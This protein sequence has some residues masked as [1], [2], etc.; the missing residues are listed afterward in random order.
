MTESLIF[1]FSIP[2]TFPVSILFVPAKNQKKKR[3]V[4]RSDKRLLRPS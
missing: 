4:E 3:G 2:L 1:F